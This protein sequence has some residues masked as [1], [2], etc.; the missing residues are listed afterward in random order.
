MIVN[1]ENLTKLEREKILDDVYNLAYNYEK[2]Y[3]NCIQCTL[4]AIKDTF[5]IIDDNVFK[6]SHGLAA[7]IGLRSTGV[8]GALSAGV[9][10][11]SILEG[12]EWKKLSEGEKP[13]SYEL[14]RKLIDK[15]EEEYGSILCH[16]IQKKIMGRSYDLS[17]SEQS[18]AYLE[19]GGRVDKCT[20]V[21]GNGAKYIAEMI[22]DGD[23]KLE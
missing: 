11:V 23:L 2:K 18:E 13:Y 21:V 15:F 1:Y 19:A 3:G 9:M 16:E 5:G 20:S 7:G 4:A 6:A 12:R 10:V 8:C 22:L 17:I 14:S